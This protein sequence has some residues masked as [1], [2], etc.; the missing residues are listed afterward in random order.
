MTDSADKKR[1]SIRKKL[2]II[3]GLLIAV[4]LI[5]ESIFAIRSTRKVV[6][7]RVRTHLTDKAVDVA[8]IID[9]R[10][11]AWF[12]LIEGI[13]RMPDLR[14]PS[15]SAADKIKILQ[16][17][18]AHNPKI[19]ELDVTDMRGYRHTVSGQTVF[20]ADGEW[21]IQA[22]NGKPFISEPIVSRS[23]NN[24]V[25][26]IA[27]PL[28]ND[29]NAII[30]VLQCLI[31]GE[32]LSDIIDD[33]KVGETGNCYVLGATGD[34]I[35]DVDRE[36]V[37]SLYN[38]VEEA[39]TD[40]SLASFA[41]FEKTAVESKIPGTGYYTYGNTKKIG[42]YANSKLADW[43]VVVKAPYEEFMGTVN[44]LSLTM[45]LIG[46]TIL[47]LTLA[48]IYFIARKMVQPVQSVGTALK[49]IAQGDGDLTV[50]LEI[51]GNDEVTELSVYFNQTIEKIGYT[52]K[53]IGEN[54]DNMKAIGNEL[55]SNMTET[56]SAVHEISS[57]IDGVKQQ[58]LTQ[59]ASVTETAATIEEIIRTI[60]QLNN[61]IEIQAASVA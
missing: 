57:N 15:I 50:R 7:D 1:F 19:L 8:E 49:N 43:T 56:A 42:G 45:D 46:L 4:V 30:G 5:G 23:D 47:L 35:A 53:S 24:F 6:T 21:F 10:I 36:Y 20:V 48:V 18:A 26:V 12:Q 2:I 51:T 25:I 33:I 22:K 9:G 11:T 37:Q 44:R 38:A 14:D 60:K 17:E 29:N 16:R 41:E 54:T 3:F 13:A 31:R 61:S 34:T 52:I 28:S 39:K 59:A 58:A 55:A 32:S 27:V 40:P